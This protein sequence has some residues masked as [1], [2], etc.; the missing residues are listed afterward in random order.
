MQRAHLFHSA[1]IHRSDY[2]KTHRHLRYRSIHIRRSGR[3][4]SFHLPRLHSNRSRHIR[5]SGSRKPECA[6]RTLCSRLPA[7]YFHFPERGASHKICRAGLFL[8]QILQTPDCRSRPVC[9][10]SAIR[11]ASAFRARSSNTGESFS[12]SSLLPLYQMLIHR[13]AVCARTYLQKRC[14]LGVRNFFFA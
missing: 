2:R 6:F 7:R 9:H 3:R 10:R 12:E 5:R 1:H 11:R 4:K 14:A 13:S 8:R